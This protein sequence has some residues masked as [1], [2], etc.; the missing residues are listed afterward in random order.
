MLETH[1]QLQ[2]L[3]TKR[4]ALSRLWYR[5]LEYK[6]SLKLLA[7]M[8]VGARARPFFPPLHSRSRMRASTDRQ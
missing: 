4:D 2:L 1:R 8:Y 7:K 3:V 5:T 6:E